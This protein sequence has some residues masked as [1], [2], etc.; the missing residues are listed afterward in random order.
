MKKKTLFAALLILCVAIASCKE[1]EGL[2]VDDSE[3]TIASETGALP[4]LSADVLEVTQPLVS[5][6]LY[7]SPDFESAVITNFDTAQEIQ[8]L[9]TTNNLFIKAR[10]HKDTSDFTG[11]VSKTILPE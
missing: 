4:R 7:T 1:R 11:F 2:K 6:R 5:G 3:A 8:V 9:D 10:L